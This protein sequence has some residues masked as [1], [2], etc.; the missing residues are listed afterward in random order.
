MYHIMY[1]TGEIFVPEEK[2]SFSDKISECM[3]RLIL[4]VS[5]FIE[6][7]QDNSLIVNEKV[8]LGIVRLELAQYN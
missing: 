6:K 3:C 4:I 1:I 5:F 7:E 8:H 2:V